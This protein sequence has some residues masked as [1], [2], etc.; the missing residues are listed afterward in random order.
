MYQKYSIFLLAFLLLSPTNGFI[1]PDQCLNV[2]ISALKGDFEHIEVKDAAFCAE[3]LLRHHQQLK[4]NFPLAS[5]FV[6][7]IA[8]E[9]TAFLLPNVAYAGASIS[10]LAVILISHHL[11]LDANRQLTEAKV[12]LEMLVETKILPTL[13]LIEEM[14]VPEKDGNAEIKRLCGVKLSVQ[15]ML[16]STVYIHQKSR[17]NIENKLIASTS[18]VEHNNIMQWLSMTVCAVGFGASVLHPFSLALASPVLIAR[19]I[20]IYGVGFFSFMFWNIK[21]KHQQTIELLKQARTNAREAEKMLRN[22]RFNI[23]KKCIEHAIQ[24][25]EKRFW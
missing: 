1:V 9:G 19:D 4:R 13:K 2:S 7:N 21:L 10:V 15:N 18:A 6:E 8:K 14:M 17:M 12:D 22:A 16:N 20:G 5:K 3:T 25:N 24:P 23:E 11:I